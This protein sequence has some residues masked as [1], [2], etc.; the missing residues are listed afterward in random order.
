[1]PEVIEEESLAEPD[2][3][4]HQRP[5]SMTCEVVPSGA[6]RGK[7]KSVDLLGYT[8]NLKGQSQYIIDWQCTVRNKNLRC[9]ANVKHQGSHFTAG[10]HPHVHQVEVCSLA[11]VKITVAVKAAG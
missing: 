4:V 8:Y 7:N 1:M 3:V 9:R 6:K 10:S 11:N 5:F 2:P